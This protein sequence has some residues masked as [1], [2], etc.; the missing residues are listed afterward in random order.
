M[1][2]LSDSIM[3]TKHHLVVMAPGAAWLTAARCRNAA[4]EL[5]PAL[6]RGELSPWRRRLPRPVRSF[7][8]VPPWSSCCLVSPFRSAGRARVLGGRLG[9]GL[10]QAGSVRA[11]AA[12]ALLGW[13]CG[14]V[15][16]QGAPG[17]SAVSKLPPYSPSLG[18]PDLMPFVVF[19][20]AD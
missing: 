12:A 18:C 3:S 20:T 11:A 17:S 2:E 7:L 9:S 16:G 10:A 14:Q 19:P 13:G 1:E 15:T 6:C 5:P 4:L 8:H